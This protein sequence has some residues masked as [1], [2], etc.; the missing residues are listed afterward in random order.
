V[1]DTRG[2]F[3]TM[4]DRSYLMQDVPVQIIWG[5]DD[6]IIPVDHARTAHA[7][8]SG[9]RLEIFED[10]GHMPFHDHPERFVDV[11]E[12]FIDSTEPADYDLDL[13]HSLMRTGG[14]ADAAPDAMAVA[15]TESAVS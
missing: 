6:L 1:V 9:S 15:P 13:M 8:I 10:S 11:V 4:L 2:Q 14:R 12:R 7:A 3:V 5:E